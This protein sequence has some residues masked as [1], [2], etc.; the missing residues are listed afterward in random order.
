MVVLADHL[1]FET[2]RSRARPGAGPAR[3]PAP[4]CCPS[5]RPSHVHCRRC[6]ARVRQDLNARSGWRARIPRTSRSSA[7]RWPG[8]MSCTPSSSVNWRRWL[9]ESQSTHRPSS[10]TSSS[11]R[12]IEA[13][14]ARPEHMQIV[15][16]SITEVAAPGVAAA[17]RDSRSS[18]LGLRGRPDHVPVLV[19]YGVTD[20]SS[21]AHGEWLAANVPGCVV[22]VDET[23][24][25]L[26]TDPEGHRE[27]PLVARRR[28]PTRKPVAHIPVRR[29]CARVSQQR[30]NVARAS[31]SVAPIATAQRFLD[32]G[33]ADGS[34]RGR[35]GIVPKPA[36]SSPARRRRPSARGQ[37]HRRRTG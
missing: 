31:C 5:R 20:V 24:G 33:E 3:S 35:C 17:R 11:A 6:A 23:A 21:P 15:R 29:G 16:E 28:P 14:L 32:G 18:T 1:G 13:E 36:A 26:A 7:G 30:G 19:R 10:A 4:P 27:P 2:S 12:R 9:R 37:V 8:K 34:I 25:H 22:K